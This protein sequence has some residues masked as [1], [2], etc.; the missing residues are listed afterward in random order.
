[1]KDCTKCAIETSR[2][3]HLA[4]L[5]AFWRDKDKSHVADLLHG[6]CMLTNIDED[7]PEAYAEMMFLK[8]LAEGNDIDLEEWK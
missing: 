7:E 5:T 6:F 1:M 3:V 2:H 8:E 4:V